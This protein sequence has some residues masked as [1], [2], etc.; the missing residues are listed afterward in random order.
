[1]L[2][3]K[4]LAQPYIDATNANG[5]SGS[6]QPRILKDGT[7][8]YNEQVIRIYVPYKID[9]SLLP[10]RLVLPACIDDIPVDVF[11]IGEIMAGGPNLSTPMQVD[12]ARRNV[13]IPMVSGISIGNYAITAGTCGVPAIK[14]SI[15]YTMSNAHVLTDDPQREVS[16][17]K[18]ILQPGKHDGGRIPAD[19]VGYYAGHTRIF[20]KVEQPSQCGVAKGYMN[21]GNFMA[22]TLG[23]RSRFNTYVAGRNN[24][25]QAWFKRNDGRDFDI[26]KTF[27]FDISDYDLCGRVFAGSTV[28]SIHCKMQYQLEAGLIPVV[29]YKPSPDEQ[30][31]RVR[32]SGRTTGDTAAP[33]LDLSGTIEVNYGNF[34]AKFEDVV[35]TNKM[36]EGGDSGS[37]LWQKVE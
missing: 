33:I 35:F 4:K 26:T 22:K 3:I 17:E 8:D 16:F 15:E 24:V 7:V 11:E 2:D 28:A 13:V 29:P 37:D 21:F 18:R 14:S 10:D 30:F 19:I 1:M 6:L 9:K 34:V 31:S 12:P 25:D 36:V 5:Y 20:P 27:D 32:K 23:R